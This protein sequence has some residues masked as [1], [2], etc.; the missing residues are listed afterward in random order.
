MSKT[1]LTVALAVAVLGLA[2]LG[3]GQGQPPGGRGRAPSARG[4]IDWEG[5]ADGN[6][7]CVN[8]CGGLAPGGCWCDADCAKH[9]DCCADKSSVCDRRAPSCEGH[10]GGQSPAGCWCDGDCSGSGD[11]CPDRAKQCDAPDPCAGVTCEQPPAPTC[12]DGTTRRSF[13]SPGTCADGAC[14]YQPSD[15]SCRFGCQDG[16]CRP[17]TCA[18]DDECAGSYCILGRCSDVRDEI[19][20]DAGQRLAVAALDGNGKL[21]LGGTISVSDSRWGVRH[22]LWHGWQDAASGPWS[23]SVLTYVAERPVR[24][25]RTPSSVQIAVVAED[26]SGIQI[27]DRVVCQ[28]SGNAEIRWFDAQYAPSGGLHTALSYSSGLYLCSDSVHRDLVT[29]DYMSGNHGLRFDASGQPEILALPLSRGPLF[30]YRKGLDAWEKSQLTTAW[31]RR[32][33]DVL[34][35][36][37][38]SHV[39]LASTDTVAVATVGDGGLSGIQEIARLTQSAEVRNAGIDSAGSVYLLVDEK[40]EDGRIPLRVYRRSPDG[41]VQSAVVA[42]PQHQPLE[43]LN[44]ALAVGQDGALFIAWEM[45]WATVAPITVRS[46]VPR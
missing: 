33:V 44:A 4:Q 25:V 27:E 6:F 7:S 41:T 10:C 29:T 43:S 5:K 30:R 8:R 39:V 46:I 32:I 26:S 21:H 13:A 19:V 37:P 14:T 9:N 45:G 24:A 36:G 22:K 31:Y 15:E 38:T 42:R 16:A 2:S 40:P 20:P 17:N 28:A 12:A 35:A 23:G 1:I 3:C 11:G 34:H 18:N